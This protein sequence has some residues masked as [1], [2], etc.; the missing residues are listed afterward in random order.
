[1][2]T[3]AALY[4]IRA[5]RGETMRAEERRAAWLFFAFQRGLMPPWGFEKPFLYVYILYATLRRRDDDGCCAQKRLASTH[6]ANYI[7]TSTFNEIAKRQDQTPGAFKCSLCK[8][9]CV[10]VLNVCKGSSLLFLSYI[11]IVLLS[12]ARASVICLTLREFLV[13]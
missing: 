13:L 1:M 12:R 7:S 6:C 3:C 8:C 4:S 10:C 9:V 5:D 11:Y 2:C